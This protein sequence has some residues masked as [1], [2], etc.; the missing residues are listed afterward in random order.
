MSFKE[1]FR[2]LINTYG[3]DILHERFRTRS[4]LSD[5]VMN[6]FYAKKLIDVFLLINSQ[7]NI[8]FILV[9]KGLVEARAF[10]QSVYPNLKS[11]AQPK[12]L[13]MQ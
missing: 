12:N 3:Y 7:Y 1:A 11:I 4:I 2:K 5:Y 10:F 6:D 8:Q 9:D 13:L